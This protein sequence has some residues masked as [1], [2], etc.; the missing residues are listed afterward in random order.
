MTGTVAYWERAETGDTAAGMAQDLTAACFGGLAALL[1][2]SSSV[3]CGLLLNMVQK[4]TF[5]SLGQM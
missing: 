4:N 2:F 1:F 5:Q 3:Y